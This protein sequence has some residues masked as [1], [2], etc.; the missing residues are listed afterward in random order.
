MMKTWTKDRFCLIRYIINNS[1]SR[2]TWK[3][4]FLRKDIE[5]ILFKDFFRQKTMSYTRLK[6]SFMYVREPRY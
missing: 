5:D 4:R 3:I 2:Q 1:P 6:I